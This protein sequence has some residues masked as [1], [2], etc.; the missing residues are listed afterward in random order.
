VLDIGCGPA[1]ILGY[2]P[3]VEYTGFDASE[4]FIAEAKR[5]WGTRG[6]FTCGTV[7]Q[8][9]AQQRRFDIAIAIGVLHHLDDAAASRLFSCAF[10]A[11]RPGGRL[12]TLDGAYVNGQSRI[13]RF[14]LSKD[15][16]KHVRAPDDYERLARKSFSDLETHIEDDLIAPVP[17]TYFIMEC[18]KPPREEVG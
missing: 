12:V 1:D 4:S 10:D 6:K 5:R 14:I 3:S 8:H 15:R 17:Y 2:L 18:S 9:T 13:A 11:L 7:E 16:G